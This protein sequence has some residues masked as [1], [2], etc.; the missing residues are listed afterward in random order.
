MTEWSPETRASRAV[1]EQVIGSGGVAAPTSGA[2]TPSG[3]LRADSVP[4][5]RRAG[6]GQCPRHQPGQCRL[7]YPRVADD[8]DAADPG[9]IDKRGPDGRALVDPLHN[10]PITGRGRRHYFLRLTASGSRDASTRAL[11]ASASAIVT[12]RSLQARQA[13]SIPSGQPETFVLNT[14]VDCMIAPFRAAV[15]VVVAAHPWSKPVEVQDSLL[16]PRSLVV[17][18]RWCAHQFREPSNG[19]MPEWQLNPWFTT[20][21]GI[22]ASKDHVRH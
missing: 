20:T 16:T 19:P 4:A 22:T 8:D 12:N 7:S 10:R 11:S 21:L 1:A 2:N 14:I 3:M 17:P 18:T 6:G 9:L 5:T 13:A 15:L